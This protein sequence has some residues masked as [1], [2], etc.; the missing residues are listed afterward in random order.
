[1]LGLSI[2]LPSF[3]PGPQLIGDVP[4]DLARRLAVGLD[5]G[6]ADGGGDNRLLRLWHV[7]QALR[8]VPR[9]SRWPLPAMPLDARGSKRQKRRFDGIRSSTA[10]APASDPEPKKRKESGVPAAA[11]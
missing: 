2:N 1:M 9:G 3:E 4:P 6:L 8:M 7:G 11:C 5:E 10:P